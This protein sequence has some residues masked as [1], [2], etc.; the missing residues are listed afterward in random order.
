MVKPVEWVDPLA[1]RTAGNNSGLAPALDRQE[2]R[3]F[4]E[5]VDREMRLDEQYDRRIGL[6]VGEGKSQ[7]G[8]SADC[9]CAK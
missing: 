2:V 7:L 4:K 9:G 5:S 8:I 6:A 1:V 3:R